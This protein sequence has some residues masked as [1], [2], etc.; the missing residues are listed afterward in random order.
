MFKRTRR[1][2][3]ATAILLAAAVSAQGAAP[4]V[5][6]QVPDDSSV[7][8]VVNDLKG[9]STKI[10]NAATRMNLPIPPDLLGMVSQKVG[11]TKGLDQNGSMALLLELPKDTDKGADQANDSGTPP[12]VLL[13]PTTDS[14]AMLAELKL[15]EPE[16]DGITP[17]TLPNGGDESG[18]VI[19][20]G[21]FVAFAQDKAALSR[22]VAHKG[23]LDKALTPELVKTFEANDV[24]VYANVP[25][26]AD[27]AIKQMDDAKQ[28]IEMMATMGAGDESAANTIKTALDMYFSGIKQVLTDSNAGAMT[29][30]LNDGGATLGFAGHFKAGSTLAKMVSA[31]KPLAG[32]NLDGLPAGTLLGAGVLKVDP[33]TMSD[34]VGKLMDLAA[35][36]PAAVKAGNVEE[37]KKAGE[38]SKQMIVLVNGNMKFAVYEP[39]DPSKGWI[40]AVEL[41]E[42]SD[43]VKY[44]ELLK[45]SAKTNFGGANAMNPAMKVSVTT[46]P[47]ALTVK[48]V[49]LNKFVMKMAFNEGADQ[50]EQS[51][52]QQKMLDTLYGPGGLT[53]YSGIVG[54]KQ[55]V[56]IVGGDEKFAEAAV[57]AAVSKS[58]ALSSAPEIAGASKDTLANPSIVGYMPVDRWIK[59][60]QKQYMGVKAPATAEGGGMAIGAAATPVTVSVGF[61]ATSGTVEM[62]VPMSTMISV[63]QT[64]MDGF[65][66]SAPM[67][68]MAPM[69]Q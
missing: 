63:T 6:E 55:L 62:H 15:G 66:Q 47:K 37:L 39:A 35:S 23:T 34:L 11:L 33:G 64:I 44:Q 22:F 52:I 29:L 26:F 41:V 20:A 42:V 27:K 48:G 14:K 28:G 57:N 58:T 31:Q 50:T 10:S 24:I 4:A 7:V 56:V 45:E 61:S 40:N 21:K 12:F 25:Q 59:L 54:E 2:V 16:K 38:L 53:L 67:Q 19:T 68:P 13:V 9:L 69:G 60:A 51:K 30:R 3:A 5:L 1:Y 43:P 36:N 32:V 65:K 46:T 49:E 18:Y 8:I 17:A